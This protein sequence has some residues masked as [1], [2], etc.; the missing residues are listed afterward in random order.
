MSLVDLV[1]RQDLEPLAAKLD[2]LLALHAQAAA[3]PAPEEPLLSVLEVVEYAGFDRKTVEKWVREGRYNEK[4]KRVYL[5]VYEFSGRWRFKRADVLAFGQS[6][7]VL[8]PTLPGEPP[9]RVQPAPKP[10]SPTA[11]VASAEALRVA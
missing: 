4:G 1:T 8:A 10:K 5:R 3:A 2:Q 9:Q 6:I 7:G 11:P